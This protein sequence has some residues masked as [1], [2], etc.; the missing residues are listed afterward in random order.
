MSIL[1][2]R[3]HGLLR[4][5]LAAV[6]ALTAGVAAPALAQPATAA[7]QG[8]YLQTCSSI[9]FSNGVLRAYCD[10]GSS[11]G[12]SLFG[13]PEF[14]EVSTVSLQTVNCDPK[15]DVFNSYGTL[16][17]IAKK[18]S[19]A[20]RAVPAGSYL[21]SC[22]A[23]LVISHVL[24][25]TCSTGYDSTIVNS[26]T[27]SSCDLS[28]GINNIS[29]QLIC[30]PA[31]PQSVAAAKAQTQPTPAPSNPVQTALKSAGCSWFLGRVNQ[32]L[33]QTQPAF[34][35]C[36]GYVAKGQIKSCMAPNQIHT[37][38]RWFLGRKTEYICTSRVAYLQ[39]ENFRTKSQLGV[40]K[41]INAAPKTT[42]MKRGARQ[43]QVEGFGRIPRLN[44]AIAVAILLISTIATI[45]STGAV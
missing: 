19:E 21:Q 18:G 14:K 40:T 11:Q 39:C 24:H 37:D 45:P 41:C 35:Q 3:L 27:L 1:A 17:C 30:A 29:G 10:D 43:P 16:F 23:I 42:A 34:K 2:K 25:A 44:D 26:L 32:Y 36:V 4:F 38:C 12:S 33:C 8:S 28:Q 15:G 7:P 13:G 5:A 22:N 31:T 20:V 9:T 6:V